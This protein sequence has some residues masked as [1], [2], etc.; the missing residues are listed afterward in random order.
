M[1]SYSTIARVDNFLYIYWQFVFSPLLN[2]GLFILLLIFVLSY[3]VF[4]M[5]YFSFKDFII[6]FFSP[7]FWTGN[8]SNAVLGMDS[9]SSNGR[10]TQI[11]SA[12]PM[13]TLYT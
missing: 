11:R 13:R 3:L 4:F 2:G 8:A 1:W 6:Y 7:N 12:I 9:P 5:F 10:V